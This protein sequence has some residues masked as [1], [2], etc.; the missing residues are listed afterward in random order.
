MRLTRDQYFIKLL[1][2]VAARSTCAR[3]AVGAIITDKGGHVLATG[4]NG[5]PAGYF[6]CDGVAYKCQGA[7]D[8]PG[9]TRR[10]LAIHAEQNALLQCHRLDLAHH[11]YV[12]CVPCFTCTKLILNTNLQYV[13]VAADY[14]DCAGA[15]LLAQQEKLY[16]FN[17]DTGTTTPYRA[18]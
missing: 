11:L 2:L 16:V 6:H 3:R 10:C 9:D 15:E 7:D 13:V 8:P 17:H 12:S 4:Y 14:A 5:T 1:A 18:R